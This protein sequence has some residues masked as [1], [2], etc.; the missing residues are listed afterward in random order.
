M[1]EVVKLTSDITPEW[2]TAALQENNVINSKVA[3]VDLEPIGAGV[4]LMAELCR[5][6]IRYT[7][8]ESAPLTMIAK[9]AA[10][11]DN[12]EVARI[13]DFYNRETN[14]YNKIGN[15]CPLKV[16]DSYFGAVNQDT[17]DCVILMEDLGDVSLRD[18]LVGASVDEA[19]S[20]I[21]NI[22]EMHAKWWNK[23]GGSDTTWMYDFMSADEAVRL[24]E[25]IYMPSLEPAI[26]KFE[27]FF[28]AEM[29]QLCR[30][31]GERYPE[32]WNEK[33]TQVD[34]FVHGDY[35]QDNMCYQ[36]DSLDAIVMDWQ[37]SGKG[38]GIFDV[39]YFLCQSVQSKVRA[40]NEQEL[41]KHYVGKLKEYGVGDYG[42]EQCWEDYKIIIL[43]CLVYPITVCGTLDTA[44]ERGR[45]L[46][47]AMLERN[48]AA[49]D[50]LGC[51]QYL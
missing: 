36:G 7:G 8:E 29:K 49:I 48:L 3:N 38:K 24:G 45:A 44:N 19:F 10:Q 35:R 30:T 14:F 22:S 32:F 23:V 25:L 26:E 40:E 4:G 51:Q 6:T 20:A 39:A 33:L 1:V 31:V 2:L 18:Q 27:S 11:N 42:F 13:L 5:L 50:E 15:D 43:G 41:L 28:S 12:I 17:Y 34:T 37:I 16:P 21:S 47:E 9:C 46:G